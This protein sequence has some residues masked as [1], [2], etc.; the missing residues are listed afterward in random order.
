MEA[1]DTRPVVEEQV[2]SLGGKFVK[3]APGETGQTKNGYAKELTE[4]QL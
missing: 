2:H 4:E 1:F 3:V